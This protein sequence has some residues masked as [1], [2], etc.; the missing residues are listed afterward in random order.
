MAPYDRTPP[1]R[2]EENSLVGSSGWRNTPMLGIFRAWAR[3]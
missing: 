1:V 3:W 2:T